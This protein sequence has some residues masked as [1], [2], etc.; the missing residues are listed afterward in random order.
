MHVEQG[1]VLHGAVCVCLCV[2]CVLTSWHV[3]VEQ[4]RVLHRAVCVCV[5]GV[6]VVCT[7]LMASCLWN[8]DVYSTE[9]CMCLCVCVCTDLMASCL[10]NRDM[11]STEQYVCVCVVCGVHVVCVYGCVCGVC[12]CGRVH[13]F[14]HDLKRLFQAHLP[15]G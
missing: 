5:C 2:W 13:S 1:R 15:A 10:W 9:Q 3:L 12:M 11:Y 4:G 8:R 6:C 7:D 14:P